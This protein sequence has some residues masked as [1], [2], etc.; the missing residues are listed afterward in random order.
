M[1]IIIIDLELVLY[2]LDLGCSTL[3]MVPN[4]CGKFSSTLILLYL[5]R[6]VIILIRLGSGVINMDSP[7]GNH[8]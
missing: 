3:L 2:H 5:F 7:R 1:T 4:I 6:Y 8:A